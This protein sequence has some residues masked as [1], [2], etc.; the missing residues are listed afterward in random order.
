MRVKRMSQIIEL[1]RYPEL[2]FGIAGPIGVDIDE[3]TT[4]LDNALKSVEYTSFHIKLTVAMRDYPAEGIAEPPENDF[5]SQTSFKMNYAN[6]LCKKYHNAATLAA[7]AIR[8]IQETRTEIKRPNPDALPERTA[9][10]IRQLKR[11]DEVALLRRVYGRQF[12]LVSAYGTIEE[13]TRKIEAKL[14]KDL[15]A[16]E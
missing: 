1:L 15:V 16:P 11:P 10:I 5:Y 2:F 14:K 13:R 8:E 4:S 6:A 3:I 9:Y 12:V 7:I